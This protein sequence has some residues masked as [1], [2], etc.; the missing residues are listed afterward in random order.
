MKS[1]EHMNQLLQILIQVIAR[2]AVPL[3]SVRGIVGSGKKQIEAF[4]LCDGTLNQTEISK[5]LK[6]DSGNFSRTVGRW[7]EDGIAFKL[8]DGKQAKLLHI[9]PL[10]KE[11]KRRAT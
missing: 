7:V 6:I 1:E 2:G 3:A 5:K 9:Y 10:G 8:G 11:T 4:N